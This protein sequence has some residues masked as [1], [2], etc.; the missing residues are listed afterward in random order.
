MT[1]QRECEL[2][3]R[4]LSAADFLE[5]RDGSRW[6]TRRAPQQQVNHYFDTRELLLAKQRILL[7]I[8][9]AEETWLTLKVGREVSPGNFDSLE[10]EHELSKQDA[11]RGLEA[12][13]SL[14]DLELQAIQELRD[15]VGHPSLVHIGTLRNERVRSGAYG[16]RANERKEASSNF[17]KKNTRGV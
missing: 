14:L 4:I 3:Y 5:L 2:K 8:R 6:G 11:T 12:P 1:A 7:R 9:E 13:G 17:H 15:R 16:L 10:V